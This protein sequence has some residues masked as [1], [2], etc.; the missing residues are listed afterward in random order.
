MEDI[1][2]PTCE[3]CKYFDKH[4]FWR[5]HHFIYACCGRCLKHGITKKDYAQVH[6][7]KG[8]EFWQS[9]EIEKSEERNNAIKKLYDFLKSINE[10][11]N[12]LEIDN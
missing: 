2:K 9:N 3:N 5:K 6:F 12:F 10:I 7:S 11:I 4:Y 8:C 1:I